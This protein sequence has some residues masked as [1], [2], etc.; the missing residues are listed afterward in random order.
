[1]VVISYENQ[2][3]NW[4]PGSS[5]ER[6][7]LVISISIVFLFLLVGVMLSKIE[8][9]EEPRDA[10]RMVP[11]RIAQFILEREKPKPKSESIPKPQP[12]PLAKVEDLPEPK[13]ETQKKEVSIKPKKPERPQPLTDT[14]KK[15]REKA[16]KSGLLALSN[17]LS[18]LID[19]SDINEMI[20]AKITSTTG[21][22]KIAHVDT[23]VLSQGSATGEPGKL[24]QLDDS[25]YSAIVGTTT[26]NA[27]ER[28]EI[29]QALMPDTNTTKENIDKQASTSTSQKTTSTGKNHS[30]TEEEIYFV[31]DQNKGKLHAVYRQARR[32]NPGLKGKIVFDITILPSGEVAS[33]VVRSSELNDPKLERRLVSRIKSFDFGSRAGEPMTVT[34]PVEFLPY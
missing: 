5:G 3:L 14:Q 24:A 26:L 16:E 21:S 6:T 17:E 31:I 1:M 29:S 7:F 11:E 8:L 27:Q 10:E 18:D 4:R 30:R 9:P 34:Y 32:A 23:S 13:P 15:A 33:V 12:K 22:S 2:A 19:T 28:L 20:G 25:K